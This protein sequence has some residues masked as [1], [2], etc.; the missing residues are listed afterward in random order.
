MITDLITLERPLVVLDLETTGINH[1]QDRIVQIGLEKF[2][3][4]GDITSWESLI[5]PTIPIP[6]EASDVH[7]ITDEMVAD[8]PTFADIANVFYAGIKECDLLGYNLWSFDKNFVITEFNRCGIKFLVPRVID[9][10]K[11]YTRFHPRNLTNAVRQYLD[12][13]HGEAHSALADAK[14]AIRVFRA[15]L[16]KHPEI[17]RTVQ[18]IHDMF[19]AAKD[20]VDP[21]NKIVWN[22][23]NE[24][25]INFGKHKG[26]PLRLVPAHYRKWLSGSAETSD[27][28]KFIM[29]ESLAGRFPVREVK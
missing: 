10:F 19:F 14:A 24:A 23:E 7:H 4:N 8:E 20:S 1:R 13:D 16:L 6:K 12:E 5:N 21:D 17:P 22:T 11:I 2:Y 9:S 26:Q 28:V 27:E 3:P 25:C 15:Q 29:T 18:E